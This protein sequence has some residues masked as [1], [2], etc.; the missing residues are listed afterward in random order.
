MGGKRFAPGAYLVSPSYWESS[1]RMR[2]AVPCPHQTGLVDL[3]TAGFPELGGNEDFS[4]REL[5]KSQD[6]VGVFY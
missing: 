3:Q 2:A 6:W 5:F 4:V 1:L